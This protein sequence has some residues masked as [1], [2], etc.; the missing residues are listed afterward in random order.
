MLEELLNRIGQVNER[1]S[2]R[3]VFGEPLQID[4]RTIIPVAKVR[5]GFG[6]GVGRSKEKQQ[7]GAGEG[8][9]G[10]AGVSISPVAVL[11]IAG[12]ETKVKPVV[13]VTRLA[14]A[15]MLLAAWNVLWITYTIRRVTAKRTAREPA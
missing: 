4:G 12:Q 3:T 8:G 5:Y 13:D 14:L 6:F 11:E 2:V 15:G 1:A 7:E 10:G 9:G